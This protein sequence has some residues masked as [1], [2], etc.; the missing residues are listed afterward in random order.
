M[1]GPLSASRQWPWVVFWSP[2]HC[3]NDR[4]RPL[5]R[6][7]SGPA[8]FIEAR[9]DTAGCTAHWVGIRQQRRYRAD[10]SALQPL[11]S[12]SRSRSI[13]SRRNS[14]AVWSNPEN[15]VRIMAH[16]AEVTPEGGDVT[17]WKVRGPIGQM[18]E[19]TSQQT[20]EEAGR[21]LS[22]QSLPGGT[23]ATRGHLA[24]QPGRENT[25]TE[26]KLWGSIRATSVRCGRG[27][28]ED[29]A[30][31]FTRD[32]RSSVAEVQEPCRDR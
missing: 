21:K 23:I 8:S 5:L 2:G 26:V 24:F 28:R 11:K 18:F 19:W 13:A 10:R 6:E 15:L 17:R 27:S 20:A 31:V 1:S 3:G 16:F 32:C 4:Q 22:W 29:T 7:S 14:L 9:A 25:G 12:S 30:G